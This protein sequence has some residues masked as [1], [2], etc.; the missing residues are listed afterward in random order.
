MN[1]NLFDTLYVM[2]RALFPKNIFDKV[3]SKMVSECPSIIPILLC[4]ELEQI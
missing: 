1:G 2:M 3:F 4:F